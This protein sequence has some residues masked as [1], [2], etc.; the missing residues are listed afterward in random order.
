MIVRGRRFQQYRE[1]FKGRGQTA[2]PFCS[3]SLAGY[4]ALQLPADGLK[5][6]IAVLAHDQQ[7]G[8]VLQGLQP[9]LLGHLVLVGQVELKAALLPVH[10][11]LE[12][13]P[14]RVRLALDRP[15]GGDAVGLGVHQGYAGSEGLHVLLCQPQRLQ[16]QRGGSV[17]RIKSADYRVVLHHFAAVVCDGLDVQVGPL[18]RRTLR[19]PAGAAGQGG[20][21]QR[22]GAQE[23]S[24]LFHQQSSPCCKNQG[25]RTVVR[26]PVVGRMP[27][28]TALYSWCGNS[29][30]TEVP[31]PT[32]LSMWI[33]APWREAPCFTM[34]RP[35][36]VPPISLEWLLST[37]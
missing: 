35:S 14:H 27:A 21:G 5:H 10:I 2:A 26:R 19:L 23:R 36:P 30:W 33:W 37:R 29:S 1:D 3:V 34:D 16:S 12:G 25:R 31:R 22:R 6:R 18:L 7:D 11:A 28:F 9:G 13:L 20:Q 32:W 8:A 24:S 17:L 4:S 15:D